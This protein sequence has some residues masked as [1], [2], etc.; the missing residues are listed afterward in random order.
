MLIRNLS[1]LSYAQGYTAWHYKGQS[2]PLA[3]ALAENF[4][5][6]ACDMMEQ[7]DTVLVSTTTGGALL[8]LQAVD[9][10][11]KSSTTVLMCR[12]P[13]IYGGSAV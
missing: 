2:L 9:K 4:F 1:V 12:T 11:E 13:S 5:S 10:V 6:P 8:F 3:T 7:G